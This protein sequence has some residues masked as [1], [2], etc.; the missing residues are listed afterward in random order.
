MAR[1]P[2]IDNL[3]RHGVLIENMLCTLALCSPSRASILTG[4]YPHQHGVQGLNG[5]L[6][7]GT[8]TLAT[9]LKAVGY[10][11]AL[12]GKWHL[13]SRPEGFDNFEILTG[14]GAYENPTFLTDWSWI[15]ANQPSKYRKNV[16]STG[17]GADIITRKAIEWL[18]RRDTYINASNSTSNSSGVGDNADLP[19][20]TGDGDGE[21]EGDGGRDT[22]GLS[23]ESG[24][25]QS[26]KDE[27]R[28]RRGAPWLLLVHFKETHEEWRYALRHAPFLS[29]RMAVPEPPTLAASLN[30]SGPLGSLGAV[31]PLT[32]LGEKMVASHFTLMSSS[33][34]SNTLLSSS[35]CASAL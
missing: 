1:T 16:E 32:R 21:G 6:R 11:T 25:D 20:V 33:H 4:Q 13:K 23:D 27:F 8:P 31:W 22:R 35:W 19:I 2:H 15:S 3:A 34:A 30:T 12:Y 24:A 17:H 18:R 14:Q 7:V 9:T 10:E 29:T 28:D 5:Q 26:S